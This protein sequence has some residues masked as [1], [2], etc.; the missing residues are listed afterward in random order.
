MGKVITFW[1]PVF[2]SGVTTTAITL[3]NK[4]SKKYNVCLLDFDLNSPDISLFLNIDDVEHN[5]DNLFPYIEGNNLS[6]EV[7]NLNT[8]KINNNFFILQGTKRID[9]GCSFKTENLEPIIDMAQSIFDF[10]L[11][12]TNSVIDNAGTYLALKKANKTLIILNQNILSFKK[13]INKMQIAKPFLNNV[14]AIINKY[15]KHLNLSLEGIKNN[16]NMD[17][18]PLSLVNENLVINDINNQFSFIEIFTGKKTRKYQKDLE[19]II[20]VIEEG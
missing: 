3:G 5:I 15:N 16:L 20:S 6:A 18:Y 7:F 8:N 2:S 19:K 17:V 13:Y 9:K 4:L 11:I 10:V 1:S 12:N 14:I